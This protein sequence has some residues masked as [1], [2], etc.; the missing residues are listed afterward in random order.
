[1]KKNTQ[2]LV[3][4]A[5]I[6]ALLLGGGAGLQFASQDLGYSTAF[7]GPKAR[8]IGAKYNSKPY[9]SGQTNDASVA[10]FD[11]TMKFDAD[12]WDNGRPNVLG[13]MTSIFVPEQSEANWLLSHLPGDTAGD[14]IKGVSYIK[15]PQPP[16]PYTWNISGKTYKMEQWLLKWFISFSATWDEAERNPSGIPEGIQ[17]PWG[18]GQRYRSYYSNAEIWFEIDITPTWYIQGGGTAY[19]AIGSVRVS[20]LKKFSRDNNGQVVNFE[21]DLSF[22]PSSEGAH[23]YMYYGLFGQQGSEATAQTYEGKELNPEYFRD[24]L[25]CHFDLNNFGITTWNEIGVVKVKGDVVTVGFDVSVFVIGEWTVKDIQ[26]IPTGFGFT[27]KTDQPA[28][29]LDFLKDPRVQAL[30]PVLVAL[31]V[32]VLLALFAPW[33]LIAIFAMFTGKR[34]R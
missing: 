6:A 26:K 24:K 8:F 9:S 4:I 12:A 27:A 3:V 22:S 16:S 25:Y 23:M 1:L 31:G 2:M 34:R 14:W 13:E 30:I 17:N 18:F 21:T 15:N 19:F 10:T 28:S 32:I 7:Q 33:V 29:L 11:T 20:D 5:L